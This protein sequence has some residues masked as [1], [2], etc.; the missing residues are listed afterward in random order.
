MATVWDTT[1][2][3]TATELMVMDTLIIVATTTAR[4]L[5]M[6]MPSPRSLATPV[7]TVPT[8]VS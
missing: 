4:D 5:L 3:A 1:A 6:L 8:P 7:S 2:T